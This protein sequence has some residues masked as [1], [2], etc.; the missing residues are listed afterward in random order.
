MYT[1]EADSANPGSIEEACEY[2][3]PMGT[4]F[5]ARRLELVA[6]AGRLWISWY[7]LGWADFHRF[8]FVKAR[9]RERSD[10][11]G[12]LPLGQKSLFIMR[13]FLA[14]RQKSL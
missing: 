4:C 14:S 10:R 6:V 5:V 11:G 3:L 9:P 13:P 7:G 2:G 8:V 1:I 12:F